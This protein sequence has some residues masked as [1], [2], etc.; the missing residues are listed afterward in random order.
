MQRTKPPVDQFC[1][2]KLAAALRI[3]YLYCLKIHWG[4]VVLFFFFPRLRTV[5]S[6]LLSHAILLKM[7]NQPYL[8]VSFCLES[9]TDVPR[10]GMD[11][12]YRKKGCDRFTTASILWPLL[13]PSL[14]KS[15]LA[16]A[17][18]TDI[19]RSQ[20]SLPPRHCVSPSHAALPRHKHKIIPL[21]HEALQNRPCCTERVVT[22]LNAAPTMGRSPKSWLRSGVQKDTAAARPEKSRGQAG[23]GG[24]RRQGTELGHGGGLLLSVPRA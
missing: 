2:I 15:L 19:F 6:P 12:P 1:G 3:L 22:P 8:K 4:F 14:Y 21:W 5:N 18:L 7:N 11:L 9:H 10:R 17:P 16:L 23:T 20:V 13:Q 24:K